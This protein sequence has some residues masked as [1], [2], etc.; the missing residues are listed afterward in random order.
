MK[1]AGE[2]SEYLYSHQ[3]ENL[4]SES[5]QIAEPRSLAAEAASANI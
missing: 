2:A 5:E 4:N 3:F 1:E